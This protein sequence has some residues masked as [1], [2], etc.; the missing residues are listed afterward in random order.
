MD[1]GGTVH[2]KAELAVQ[3]LVLRGCYPKDALGMSWTQDADIAKKFAFGH[4]EMDVPRDRS[5][6]QLLV[7]RDIVLGVLYDRHEDEY[8]IDPTG[9]TMTDLIDVTPSP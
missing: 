2:S 8:I 6:Y 5:I 1:D 4:G 9:L 3:T 7:S